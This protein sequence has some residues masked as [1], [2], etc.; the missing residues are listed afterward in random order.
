MHRDNF[1]QLT[2]NHRAFGTG[3]KAVMLGAQTIA[4]GQQDVVLA[5]GTER[6]S[7]N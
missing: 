1:F 6:F 5:G 3:L 2:R 7:H 4:L